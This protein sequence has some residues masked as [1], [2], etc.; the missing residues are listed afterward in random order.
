MVAGGAAPSPYAKAFDPAQLPR[1]QAV[2]KD[3]DCWLNHFDR[4]PTSATSA[5]ATPTPS[6]RPRLSARRR[7]LSRP[8]R[9]AGPLDP[10]RRR[11]RLSGR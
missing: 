4:A 3:L 9:S 6:R 11:L 2:E 1:I 10:R 5:T 8:A 7:A